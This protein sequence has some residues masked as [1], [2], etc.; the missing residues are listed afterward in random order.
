MVQYVVSCEW[1]DEDDS[2]DGYLQ[3]G[4]DGEDFIAL[5]LKTL[6]WVAPVRQA[7]STKQRWDQERAGLQFNKYFL[8]KQCVDWL[9]MVLAYG[10]ST[11]QRTGRVT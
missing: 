3:Y 8:T 10:K 11:L 1:D 2:T 5:D 4:Y 9:K 6:T 7:F